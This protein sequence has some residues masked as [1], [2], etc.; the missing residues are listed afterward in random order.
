MNNDLLVASSSIPYLFWLCFHWVFKGQ[1]CSTLHLTNM[2]G[3]SHSVVHYKI[4][5]LELLWL[6]HIT[7]VLN[8]VYGE[9]RLFLCFSLRMYV[10]LTLFNIVWWEVNVS[11]DCYQDDLFDL[12]HFGDCDVIFYSLNTFLSFFFSLIILFC[13]F[14]F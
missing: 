2:W 5:Q 13:F 9:E 3:V 8:K 1:S 7:F 6:L 11:L 14:C 4:W 10:L 12:M